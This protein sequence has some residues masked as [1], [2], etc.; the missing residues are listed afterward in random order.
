M[1][2][3]RLRVEEPFFRP[4]LLADCNQSDQRLTAVRTSLASPPRSRKPSTPE[5]DNTTFRLGSRRPRYSNASR[6]RVVLLSSRYLESLSGN[7]RILP[8]SR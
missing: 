1:E 5:T 2:G 6:T 7:G 8:T 4:S 3:C